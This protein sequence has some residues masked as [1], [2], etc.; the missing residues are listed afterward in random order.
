MYL[1]AEELA[2][3]MGEMLGLVVEEYYHLRT[4]E[5]SIGGEPALL[6][7]SIAEEL[8]GGQVQFWLVFAV[9]GRQAVI[10]MLS[11]QADRFAETEPTFQEILDSFAFAD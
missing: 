11:A 10:V 4:E 1:T 5:T 8:S 7:T 3:D 6:Q 2:A 9:H